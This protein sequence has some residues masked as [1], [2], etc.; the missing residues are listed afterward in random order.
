MGYLDN[1]EATAQTIDK[2]SWIHTGDIAYQK[3][4]KLYI[5][6]RAKVS[7]FYDHCSSGMH[8]RA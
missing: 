3:N 7:A 4:G 5:I 6:D 2:D 1:A 8:S